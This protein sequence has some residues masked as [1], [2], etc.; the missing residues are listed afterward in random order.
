MFNEGFNLNDRVKIN[1]IHDMFDGKEGTIVKIEPLKISGFNLYRVEF[2]IG[3]HKEY[4]AHDMHLVRPE[5]YEIEIDDNAIR[6][7]IYDIV[8]FIIKINN[9]IGSI[10]MYDIGTEDNEERMKKALKFVKDWL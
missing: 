7:T 4:V 1:K 6:I 9:E 10:R 3:V 5:D 8:I 2:D